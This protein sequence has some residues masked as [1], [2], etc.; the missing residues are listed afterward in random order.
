M[1]IFSNKKRK[2]LLQG[3]TLQKIQIHKN[4]N[5][6]S[7]REKENCRSKH[8]LIGIISVTTS[9]DQN[10]NWPL[11]T[12]SW[13]LLTPRRDFQNKSNENH[14]EVSIPGKQTK[15]GVKRTAQFYTAEMKTKWD[16]EILLK[17]KKM[18]NTL[19]KYTKYNAKNLKKPKSPRRQLNC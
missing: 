19:S 10:Q 6:N 11:F 16:Y 15:S 5:K 12:T 17:S 13:D 1:S 18:R 7:N 9:L 14:S 3:K 2:I 4:V 8:Q